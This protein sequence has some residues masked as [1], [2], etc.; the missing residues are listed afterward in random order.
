MGLRMRPFI[1]GAVTAAFCGMP[2]FAADLPT[3]APLRPVPQAVGGFFGEVTGAYVFS[4]PIQGWEEFGPGESS[5]PSTQAGLGQ[6][7][8]GRILG[9]YRWDSWDVA[10]AAQYGRF[11][12][13]GPS[14]NQ[15]G[16]TATLSAKMQAYDAQLGYHTMFG[17][18]DTRLAVGI[19]YARWDNTVAATDSLGIQFANIFHDWRGVGPRVE[20]STKTPLAP[21]VLLRGN[22]GVA[23]L[24]GKIDTSATSRWDCSQCNSNTVTTAD[25]DGSIGLG[26][27]LGSNVEFVVGY[28]AEYWSNVNV[29]ITDNSGAGLN[30]GTSDV[31]SHGPFV[32]LKLGSVP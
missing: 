17:S 25:I 16:S 18:T 14:I 1:A 26:F 5:P 19:R 15:S 2:V 3:K 13:G 10:L 8:T 4:D 27:P 20:I 9:G 30:Q 21:N 28:K 22:L 11:A 29:A 12:D 7:W 6:G 24:F 32:T 23:A 31:L